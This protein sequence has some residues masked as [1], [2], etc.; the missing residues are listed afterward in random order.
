MFQKYSETLDMSY[1]DPE[2]LYKMEESLNITSCTSLP[3]FNIHSD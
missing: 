2:I 1:I 3:E